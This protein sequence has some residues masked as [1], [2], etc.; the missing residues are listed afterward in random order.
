MAE[1]LEKMGPDGVP[2]LWPVTQDGKPIGS[3]CWTYF[4]E[5]FDQEKHPI[6]VHSRN[7][8]SWRMIASG[9][10]HYYD[11]A[12][13]YWLDPAEDRVYENAF[14]YLCYDGTV[15]TPARAYAPEDG[16]ELPQGWAALP[17]FTGSYVSLGDGVTLNRA[18]QFCF[19]D[20]EDPA[21]LWFDELDRY[22]DGITLVRRG[23]CWGALN[24]DREF[25]IPCEMEALSYDPYAVPV[26]ANVPWGLFTYKHRQSG[27]RGVMD[28]E[29]N[30]G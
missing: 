13:E 21:A 4:E 8:N 29:G 26:R 1:Y 25:L 23:D 15:L 22:E 2:R 6:R 11:A 16:E 24:E 17:K 10:E 12:P 20:P 14:Y 18:G 9:E 30:T 7:E 3:R 5:L 19:G 28:R 27:R